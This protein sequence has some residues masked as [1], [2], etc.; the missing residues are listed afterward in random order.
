MYRTGDLARWRADGVLEFVG[1]ADQQLKIRG[2]RIEPG[3]IEAALL[4]HE[5]VQDALVTVQE[6]SGQKQLLGYVVSRPDEAGQAPGRAS[7]IGHWRELYE[8]TYRQGS[9]PVGDFNIVGWNSSYTGGPIPAAEMRVWVEEA[10][11][12]LRALRPSRVLEIGCGTG[13]LLT[14]LAP[15]CESYL[16]LDFSGRVLAQL[17]EYLSSREDLGHVVLRE[18]LA[19]DLSFLGDDSVDLVVINSVAQYFPDV[20]YL[21]EVLAEA[22]RVTRR[23]GHVFVGDVRSLPLLEAYHTS[24]ELYRSPGE[25]PLGDLRQ[26]IGQAQ[27]NEKELLVDPALFS[28]LGRRWE[29]LGR[30][31]TSLKAGSYDNELS[32]FRYDVTLRLGEREAVAA[33]ERWLPWDEAGS[34]REALAEA[35]AQGPGFAIGIRGIRDSRVASAV[36]AVRLLRDG[37]SLLSD[38]RQLRAAC[39]GASGDDADA[40]MRL[41]QRLGVAFCWQRL[42]PDGTSDGVF[43]PRWRGLDAAA[44][45]PRSYYWRYGNAP[46]QSLG[47]AELGRALQAYLRQSLPDY[48]VPSAIVALASWPLT[49]NGKL[50]RK[51]LPVPGRTGRVGGEY[52]EPRGETARLL[53]GL[54][55][56][57]LGLDRVGEED[58]FF[59]LGGHSLMATQVMSRVRKVFGVELTVRALFEAPQLGDLARVVED[60]QRAA[61]DVK[62]PLRAQAR[63]ERLPLSYAQQ[64]LWF[65]DQLAGTSA[66]YNMPE[67]LRLRGELDREALERTVSAIVERH[68]SLRT[69][70]VAVDGEPVQVIVPALRIPVPVDD[71]SGLDEALRPAAAQAAWRR[72]WEQPFDLGRGPLLRLRLLKLAEQDHILLRAWHHIVSDGWSMG[73]FNREFAALYEAFQEGRGN[74]LEPLPVQYADFA[75][76]QRSWLDDE[77]VSRGLGY[78]K[79]QLSGIPEQLALPADRPRPAVQTFAAELCSLTL[80]PDRVAALKRL[81]QANQATL[82]MTLLSGFAVLLQRY[83]GQDDIVVGSPI[84][85]R[86]EPQ[87]EQLIGFFVNSLVMRVQVGAEVSFRELLLAVRST[88][89]DAYQHQD[90]PFERLVEELS[91]ERSLSR[92]PVFQ[93]VFAL[94]N[95]PA[96]PQRLK[97]LE[98][99]PV[100]GDELRVRFDLE[101]HAVERDGGLDLAWLY[102]RDLFDRWRMEQMARHYVTVLEAAV[103]APDAPLHR[104]EILDAGER[105]TLLE[106]FN[107]TARPVPEATLPE[108]F[109]AQAARTPAA[110]AVTSEEGTLSYAELNARANQLAHHLVGWGVGPESLVG[111]ALERSPELV[112][113]LL[114]VLKAGGAYLPLD[115]DYPQARLAQMLG[116]A[117]PALVLSTQALHGRLPEATEVVELDAPETQAALGRAPADNPTDTARIAPLLPQHPAYVIYTSGSTGLPKGVV[118]THSGI[119]GLAGTQVE[120]LG[121]T[122]DSRVVQFAPLGFDASLWEIAMALT[123]GAALIL[124]KE[125]ARS[126]PPLREVLVAQRATHATLPP[127]VLATLESGADLSLEAL[128]VAGEPCPGELVG[129]WSPGRCMINAYGPTEVTV[130]ATMSAP[131]SGMQAPPI[132]RPIWNTRMYV[133]DAGLEPV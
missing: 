1:R 24:V 11:S 79:A 89:L 54:W 9:T 77:T 113:A 116:D 69:H 110:L 48:M 97:G 31:E 25:L 78:W 121:L 55:E 38:A 123:T 76:W 51:A 122:P 100:V 53:A 29:K 17:G 50:D 8:T 132:G 84:A 133:L 80:P 74:P 32:R 12:R 35:L 21:L 34:W 7:H 91:P 108:L 72:E 18:G 6:Q 101:V 67:A 20:D 28:E 19:Q 52:A 41:A 4:T 30:V 61:G 37:G 115:P 131:L 68:E 126:G 88:T 64:R 102:N 98:I 96:G 3:E 114:A 103:S 46:S 45:A 95:A 130:C 90:I 44:D 14:R 15:S 82:Y 120:R 57:V 109:E 105:R 39:A 104:L 2:F 124:L 129:C 56:A 111:I 125:E 23:G 73:V 127:V 117:A 106:D 87:L 33:P 36:E 42:G 13:L 59:A 112:V 99:A 92:P 81:G 93:V 75:L 16:G 85:N 47:D 70:F 86:Q 119:P 62:P 40:I 83:S 10:V 58:D 63:P 26:R 60:A 22:V 65:V 66:E 71:L 128:I 94:Q 118:V 27:L 107:A 43:N 49:P 5:R